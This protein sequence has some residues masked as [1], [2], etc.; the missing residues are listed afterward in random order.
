MLTQGYTP[1]IAALV[2]K[3]VVRDIATMN[4]ANAENKAGVV[5]HWG[6][7]VPYAGRSVLCVG[8]DEMDES[9]AIAAL[10]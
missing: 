5:T 9:K 6:H 4:K 10:S 1:E 7:A 3:S 2:H 8:I